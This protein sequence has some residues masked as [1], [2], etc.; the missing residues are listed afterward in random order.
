MNGCWQIRHND[1]FLCTSKTGFPR[2]E[3]NIVQKTIYSFR[4]YCQGK[5]NRNFYEFLD[6]GLGPRHIEATC[7][8]Y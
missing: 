3:F 6:K 2:K 1:I 8:T 7:F 5:F 4:K